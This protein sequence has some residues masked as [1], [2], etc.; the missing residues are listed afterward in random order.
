MVEVRLMTI[1]MIKSYF[2]KL[3]SEG[4]F[5]IELMEKNAI[6][7]KDAVKLR[8]TPF[9]GKMLKLGR[10][11]EENGKFYLSDIGYKIAKG[12]KRIYG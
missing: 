5:L 3:D 7:R 12:A 10:I 9:I 6:K 11:E 8:K 1:K 2:P 4:K